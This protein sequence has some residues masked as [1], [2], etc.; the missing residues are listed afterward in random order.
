MHDSY[1]P[2]T[3]R[4]ARAPHDEFLVLSRYWKRPEYN[5]TIKF[6]VIEFIF[7]R[8]IASDSRL[9]LAGAAS[10]PRFLSRIRTPAI[11]NA[12]GKRSTWEFTQSYSNYTAASREFSR[13]DRNHSRNKSG[14]NNNWPKYSADT[15]ATGMPLKIIRPERARLD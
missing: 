14:G 15:A 13:V 10:Y 9:S 1:R 2:G 4:A 7:A 11:E 8:F 3:S 6:L 12:M 5:A